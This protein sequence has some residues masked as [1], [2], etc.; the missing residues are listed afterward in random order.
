[1]SEEA[2]PEA[3][4]L[5]ASAIVRW[6]DPPA[7]ITGK[8]GTGRRIWPLTA[9]LLK[10]NPNRWALIADDESQPSVVARINGGIG[11]WA[12]SGAFQGTSRKS[13]AVHL[14]YA[15]YVGVPPTLDA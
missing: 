14:I 6:E 12:P 15:R 4:A 5:I 9:A 1:M 10:A 13:G 2:A 11:A 7:L 3:A 8:R